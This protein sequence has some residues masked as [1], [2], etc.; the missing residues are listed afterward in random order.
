MMYTKLQITHLENICILSEDI[1]PCLFTQKIQFASMILIYYLT[2][3][4]AEFF[5][6]ENQCYST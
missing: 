4:A 5:E 2:S 1:F 3:F 6:N